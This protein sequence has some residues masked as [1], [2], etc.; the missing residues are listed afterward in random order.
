MENLIKKLPNELKDLIIQYDG[1][2]KFR[3]GVYM[4]Q[5]D[6]KDDRYQLLRSM[7]RKEFYETTLN[8][9]TPVNET[10]MFNNKF[11]R[12]TFVFFRNKRYENN[13][14]FAIYFEE[15]LEP[16]PYKITHHFFLQSMFS[17]HQTFILP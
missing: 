4:N 14:F 9:Y 15:Q 7:S 12:E 2:I 16:Q 5:I 10:F 1:S 3:N 13:T 11:L 6:K 8:S 17:D